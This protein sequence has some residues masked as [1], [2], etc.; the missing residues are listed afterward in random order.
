M[1][2]F[3]RL[4]DRFGHWLAGRL[5]S[6]TP[7]EEPFIP[8]DREALRR[9]LRTGDVLLVAGGSTLS[10]AIKYLTQSTW[11]HAALYVGARLM[12]SDPQAIRRSVT[13]RDGESDAEVFTISLD[14]YHD[15]RTAYAFSISSGSTPALRHRISRP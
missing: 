5:E 12:R 3:D 1:G 15:R 7:G 4:L 11:S 10:T 14:T 9:T 8:T 6:E 13:R 2:P